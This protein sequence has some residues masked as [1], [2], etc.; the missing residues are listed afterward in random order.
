MFDQLAFDD[1]RPRT[2]LDAFPW[3]RRVSSGHVETP[4]WDAAIDAAAPDERRRRLGQVSELAVARLSR[5]TIGQ[6][7]PGLPPGLDVRDLDLV[8]RAENVLVRGGYTTTGTLVSLTIENLFDFRGVGGTVIDCILQ[9]LADVSTSLPTPVVAP[10]GEFESHSGVLFD[11][12]RTAGWH[13]SFTDD[14]SR[15]AAWQT[16]I[17]LPSEPI[18]GSPL[19]AAAPDEVLKARQRLEELS[20]SD[21]LGAGEHDLDAAGLLDRAFRALDP[22]ALQVLRERLFADEPAKLEQLGRQLDISRERVRQ[23]EG[24]AR[25]AMLDAFANDLLDMVATT[26]RTLIGTIRPLSELLA[27]MPALAR[28]VESVEQPAWRVIDR[29]DDAYEIEDGWC[30][31]PTLTAA[32]EWTRTHLREHANHY[33][34]VRVDDLDL[35]ETITPD[36]REDLTKKWLSTCGYVID[37]D[38]VLTRTGATHDY[39]AAVLSIDG[40]PM[41]S[42]EI[43]DRFTFERSAGSLRNAMSVDDRFVRV[44]RDRWALNE[45]GMD[46]YS[47]VRSVIREELAKAGG[48]IKL[49]V[50]V[51]H[52]TGK[53]SVSASSVVAYSSAPPFVTRDGVVRLA[54]S[55]RGIRKAPER[56]SRLF[57]WDHAWAYR[58]RVT[59]DHLRGSGWQA[60][61]AIATILNL[62]FGEK[63]ALKS[64]LGPQSINW[65]G[66]QPA[67]GSIRRFLVEDDVSAGQDV[68][69]VIGDDNRFGVVVASEVIGEPLPDALSLVGA[70]QDLDVASAREAV[71]AAIKMPVD[72]PVV[73]I[74]G[75]YRERGDSDVADLLTSVRRYLETGEPNERVPQTTD[76]DDILSLL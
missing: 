10:S 49:S 55:S 35:V 36:V 66:A 34:V 40:S 23:I 47:G 33:G 64:D 71:A 43:I 18:L 75:G 73:S 16:A 56:T 32:K 31:A 67:F 6:I 29:L 39:A 30:V 63:R 1:L 52:I 62:E 37:G 70:P 76:I 11:E 2:W 15:I 69:L 61:M 59:H 48:K 41:S 9:T 24:K 21:V 12:H 44:D 19:S 54:G 28:T 65:T 20:A 58:V 53:Y 26:A 25:A 42:Q 51:E 57:R 17:G 22:R 27:L 14:V 72:S 46:A 68:F 4:W 50:L 8:T 13:F 60:P 5:W 38:Y 74:I 3:L 7:F 45:W